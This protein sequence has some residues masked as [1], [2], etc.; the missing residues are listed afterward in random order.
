MDIRTAACNFYFLLK[1]PTSDLSS[2]QTDER[3]RLSRAGEEDWEVVNESAKT[4]LDTYMMLRQLPGLIQDM[5][6]QMRSNPVTLAERCRYYRLFADLEKS[7]LGQNTGGKDNFQNALE[8]AQITDAPETHLTKL[9]L[10]KAARLLGVPHHPSCLLRLYQLGIDQLLPFLRPE[11]LGA[12]RELKIPMTDWLT[13]SA[14]RATKLSTSNVLE[15]KET[16]QSPMS[17]PSQWDAL[18]VS[19]AAESRWAQQPKYKICELV[20]GTIVTL[21]HEGLMVWSQGQS[22]YAQPYPGRSVDRILPLTDGRFATRCGA[23]PWTIWSPD[24]MTSLKF[25]VIPATSSE[26]LV[27]L[28]NQRWISVFK[29]YRSGEV[30]LRL[31]AHDGSEIAICKTAKTVTGL[32]ALPHSSF[33]AIVDGRPLVFVCDGEKTTEI[34]MPDW[35][36]GD[37]ACGIVRAE[38][39]RIVAATRQGRLYFWDLQTHMVTCDPSLL[40]QDKYLLQLLSLSNGMIVAQYK[41]RLRVWANVLTQPSEIPLKGKHSQSRCLSIRTTFEPALWVTYADGVRVRWTPLKGQ[42]T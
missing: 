22:K 18:V 24:L 5:D 32:I 37:P 40:L 30:S 17:E 2:L 4:I 39:G 16:N 42:G 21:S 14:I 12:L 3:G 36:S 1:T 13:Q 28:T 23:A 9:T 27:V 6:E 34:Q 26:N 31:H 41:E 29:N 8:W 33:A 38:D 20:D 11:E 25:P 19:T 7:A 35:A 15:T 10:G